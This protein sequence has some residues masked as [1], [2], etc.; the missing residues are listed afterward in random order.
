MSHN[1]DIKPDVNKDYND[2]KNNKKD[3]S[4][5]TESTGNNTYDPIIEANKNNNVINDYVINDYKSSKLGKP[6]TVRVSLEMS[7]KIEALAKEWDRD[8]SWVIRY[9]ILA[10]LVSAD[11]KRKDPDLLKELENRPRM[12]IVVET[13]KDPAKELLFSEDWKVLEKKR[14]AIERGF[15]KLAVA[16]TKEEATDIITGFI[17]DLNKQYRQMAAEYVKKSGQP[18]KELFDYCDQVERR[19]KS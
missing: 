13:S 18:H 19:L 3:T 7:S 2:Y 6:Y 17:E 10:G 8:P 1:T 9:L 12:V 14:A 5:T 16:K 15:N 4:I 11:F